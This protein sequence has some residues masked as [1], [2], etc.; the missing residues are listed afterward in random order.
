MGEAGK[1][2]RFGGMLKN[3]GL[4]FNKLRNLLLHACSR[5]INKKVLRKAVAGA[6]V[7]RV[8]GWNMGAELGAFGSGC[9]SGN[10]WG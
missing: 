9:G 6:A 2:G 1:N 10:F 5:S 4:T 7:R 8:E 3:R